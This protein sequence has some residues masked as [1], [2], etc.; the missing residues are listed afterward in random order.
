MLLTHWEQGLE[1]SHPILEST[2]LV[3]DDGSRGYHEVD[4]LW[5]SFVP[6]AD[7]VLG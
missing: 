7:P 2:G 6:E 1:R 4:F 3:K 5:L